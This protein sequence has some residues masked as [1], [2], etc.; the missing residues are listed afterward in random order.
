MTEQKKLSVKKIEN[1]KKFYENSV[2]LRSKHYLLY[3]KTVS[4]PGEAVSSPGLTRGSTSSVSFAAVASKKGVSKSAVKRN[5]A[6][7]RLKNAFFEYM[8]TAEN[9][10][11]KEINLVF[12]ANRSVLHCEWSELKNQ[13]AR[14]CAPFFD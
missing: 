5:R 1:F 10:N 8:K 11:S 6:K 3:Y 12:M 13:I 2:K 9:K 4:S 14:T 7:R